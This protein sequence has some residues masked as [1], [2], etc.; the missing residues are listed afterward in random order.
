M[1][2]GA[3]IRENSAKIE[4]CGHDTKKLYN[5]VNNMT[6]RTK[7]NPMPP[8]RKDTELANEFADFFLDKIRRIRD[9]LADCRTYTPNEIEVEPLENFNP[10]SVEEVV[11]I[12]RSMPTRVVRAMYCL[13]VYSR[14]PWTDL[15]KP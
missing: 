7:T 4:M 13:P 5:L 6:G 12:I 9:D 3:K 8:G 2:A 1:I 10:L 14:D 11:S 15:E